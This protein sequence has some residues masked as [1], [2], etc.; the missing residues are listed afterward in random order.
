MQRHTHACD[1]PATTRPAGARTSAEVEPE[2]ARSEASRSSDRRSGMARS[3]RSRTRASI[4]LVRPSQAAI[5]MASAGSRGRATRSHSRPTP[6]RAATAGSS[7]PSRSSQA[8]RPPAAWAAASVPSAS[9]VAPLPAGASRRASAPRG[10]PRSRGRRRATMAG[11]DRRARLPA[12]ADRCR[13]AAQAS[14]AKRLEGVRQG[15]R[16]GYIGP[17][18]TTD[19]RTDVLVGEAPI[20]FVILAAGPWGCSSAGRAPR[21]HRGGQGFESPHLHQHPRPRRAA[22]DGAGQAGRRAAT[23]SGRAK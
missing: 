12:S 23:D 3:P 6:R 18:R 9:V 2:R 20:P 13:D 8:V 17:H 14:C 21:S 4:R 16:N 15:W 7:V 11:R 22:S 5:S 1:P 19:D 10:Q